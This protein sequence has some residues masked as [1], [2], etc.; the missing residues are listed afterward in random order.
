MQIHH[1]VTAYV[2]RFVL[3]PELGPTKRRELV[4]KASDISVVSNADYG[5]FGVGADGTF[6]VPDAFGQFLLGHQTSNGTWHQGPSPFAPEQPE[7]TPRGRPRKPT[8]V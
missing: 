8:E 7:P 2:D 5:E 3:D 1:V 4:M 6:D